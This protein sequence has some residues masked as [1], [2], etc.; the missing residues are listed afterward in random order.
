V[1]SLHLGPGRRF[2]FIKKKKPRKKHTCLH[3]KQNKHKKK[4]TTK[5]K[6][7]KKQKNEKQNKGQNCASLLDDLLL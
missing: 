1:V 6:T 4:A 5:T 2:L 7:S 3:K